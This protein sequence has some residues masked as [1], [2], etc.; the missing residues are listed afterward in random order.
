MSSISLFK[1]KI[2]PSCSP[3]L[4]PIILFVNY[5][6]FVNEVHHQPLSSS[7]FEILSLLSPSPTIFSRKI[8]SV[9]LFE[10]CLTSDPS[11]IVDY[12]DFIFLIIQMV[13]LQPIV[14]TDS[15][16]HRS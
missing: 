11:S 6:S 3:T 9:F 16:P 12:D 7:W 10:V 5:S 13:E 1:P 8:L 14:A 15:A 4:Y 2:K